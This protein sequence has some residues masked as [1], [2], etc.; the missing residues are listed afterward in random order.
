VSAVV[1]F[2]I[3]ALL[4]PD[5]REPRYVGCTRHRPH[6]R[7]TDHIGEAVPYG[8]IG[9]PVQRWLQTLVGS[10]KL[11]LVRVLATCSTPADRVLPHK[12]PPLA[13]AIERSWIHHLFER[14]SLLNVEWRLRKVPVGLY[15]VAPRRR[16]VSRLREVVFVARQAGGV[17]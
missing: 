4:D 17:R 8:E 13:C 9:P 6:Q 10:G 3:Y 12:N 14:F 1:R 11:P 2:T 7:A 16:L 15:A 5:T